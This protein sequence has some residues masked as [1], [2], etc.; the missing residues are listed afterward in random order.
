MTQHQNEPLLCVKE[1]AGRLGRNRTYVFAMRR[2]GFKMPGN[3]AT[4]SSALAWLE[5][6]PKPRSGR[7]I[8]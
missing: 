1:L 5:S 7:K 4:L 3:V 2:M 6:H 8:K